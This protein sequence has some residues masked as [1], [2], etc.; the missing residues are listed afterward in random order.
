MSLV[1]K[2]KHTGLIGISLSSLLLSTQ[3]PRLPD[4]AG[5]RCRSCRRLP[6]AAGA[7]SA[8]AGVAPDE[9]CCAGTCSGVRGIRALVAGVVLLV[10]ES[11]LDD[12]GLVATAGALN[13]LDVFL[14]VG[15]DG[16]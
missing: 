4:R 14:I 5:D 12:P 16:L 9:D 7:S 13:P 3:C 1:F 2:F 11:A 6:A 10:L 15:Q 8:C